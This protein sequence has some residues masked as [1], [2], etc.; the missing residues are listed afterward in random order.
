[1]A[2][3][4]IFTIIV[5]IIV[6]NSTFLT[7]YLLNFAYESCP[8]DKRYGQLGVTGKIKETFT[9]KHRYRTH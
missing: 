1:M 2:I 4:S 8:L 5:H 6:D 3:V 7:E 9:F